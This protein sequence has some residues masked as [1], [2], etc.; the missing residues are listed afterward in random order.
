MFQETLMYNKS[1]E[2]GGTIEYKQKHLFKRKLQTTVKPQEISLGDR[3][4][5]RPYSMR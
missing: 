1:S 5:Y 2:E 3:R 4:Y